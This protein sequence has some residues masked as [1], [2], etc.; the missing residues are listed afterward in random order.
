MPNLQVYH[1][2]ELDKQN[3]TGSNTNTSSGKVFFSNTTN[4]TNTTTN[5]NTNTTAAATAT[6][7][8]VI[9]TASLPPGIQKGS[10]STTGSE[11]GATGTSSPISKARHGSIQSLPNNIIPFAP[12]PIPEEGPVDESPPMSGTSRQG[13]EN[14]LAIV[15]G[16]ESEGGGEYEIFTL[17]QP[18]GASF[19]NGEDSDSNSDDSSSD[20]DDFR[21]LGS[22][23]DSSTDSSSATST[24]D[25]ESFSERM[26]YFT[27]DE[28]DSELDE[29]VFADND[30]RTVS[31]I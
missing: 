4:K 13:S 29:I 8:P 30:D 25:E 15:G 3:S 23:F 22:L 31:Y 28:L 12:S 16:F 9:S 11:A 7:S 6:S 17:T 27:D 10:L 14:D 5:N 21:G 24:V 19:P 18:P 20:D 1:N 2:N 26:G